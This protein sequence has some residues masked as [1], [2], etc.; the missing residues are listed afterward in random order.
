MSQAGNRFY[1]LRAPMKFAR[2]TA[3]LLLVVSPQ[4]MAQ[5]LLTLD[6]AIEQALER[7]FAIQIALNDLDIARRNRSIG[8]AGF[9]PRAAL[10]ATQSGS[11]INSRQ[12]FLVGGDPINRSG[13]LSGRHSAGA[14]MSWRVF[15]GMGRFATLDRLGAQQ[16]LVEADAERV[17]SNAIADVTIAFYD[18]ARQQQQQRV[19]RDAVNLSE[20][21]V[22]IAEVRFDLG[23]AS[24][25]EVR[26]AR[27]ALNEDRAALLRQDVTIADARTRLAAL[28]GG[29]AI[30][31]FVVADTIVLGEAPDL[32]VLLRQALSANPQL[33]AA[34]ERLQVSAALRREIA[35]ERFPTVDAN[36]GYDYSGFSAQTGTIANS[37][38]LD[39]N[40]GLSASFTLFDGFNR[41]RRI[42]NAT[43]VERSASLQIDEVVTRVELDI[44]NLHETY[45][46]RLALIA[47]ERENLEITRANL[48]VALERFRLGT[49]TSV[50]LREV[51][52]TL[53][54][55]ESR[56]INA[57]FE[58]KRAETDLIRLTGSPR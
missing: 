45:L 48:E 12:E 56:L 28:M 19:L 53:T 41:Q 2:L 20:E 46:N 11:V 34:R 47:L 17:V 24:E 33:I 35:A 5:P 29:V 50:E 39:L 58:A 57:A 23:S 1:A 26:R 16:D 54:R 4:V 10:N 40:Y 15:D 43:V 8:N 30:R 6:D 44:I 42:Q 27:A 49:I 51:Q 36:A 18:I 52:E 22:R 25:L 21:R 3:L 9:L 37:R 55:A 14:R 38:S 31:N 32:Q 13:A 7:N